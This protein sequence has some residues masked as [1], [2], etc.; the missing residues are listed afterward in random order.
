M[1]VDDVVSDPGP[2]DVG[3]ERS[4]EAIVALG[5]LSPD[6]VEVQLVR[7]RVVRDGDLAET[8][9]QPMELAGDEPEDHLRYRATFVCEQAGR[10]GVTV[11]V[12]PSNPLLATPVELGHIAWA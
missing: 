11:R 1:H 9:V 7:G 3:T 10:V 5:D 12:V 2:A 6:D 4:V 8:T